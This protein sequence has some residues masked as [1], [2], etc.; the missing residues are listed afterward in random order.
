MFTRRQLDFAMLI[1]TQE[2]FHTNVP[3]YDTNR[4]KKKW[5]SILAAEVDGCINN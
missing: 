5:R 2:K 3:R 1:V 4:L